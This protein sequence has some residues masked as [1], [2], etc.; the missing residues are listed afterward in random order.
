MIEDFDRIIDATI[1]AHKNLPHFDFIGW[2]VTID[3]KNEVVIIEFNPDP[4]MRLD[5]LIF[6]DTCLLSHQKEILKVVYK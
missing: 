3:D 5:Q 1:T 4:D 2:D 6:M